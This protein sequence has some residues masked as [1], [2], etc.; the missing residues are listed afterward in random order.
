MLSSS[1]CYLC[2]EICQ[3]RLK[4]EVCAWIGCSKGR[5]TSV[6]CSRGGTANFSLL[7]LDS[8]VW[9]EQQTKVCCPRDSKLQFAELPALLL[10]NAGSKVFLILP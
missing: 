10:A 6:W 9:Y 4:D 7:H 8:H 5:Q 3:T 1:F 2:L